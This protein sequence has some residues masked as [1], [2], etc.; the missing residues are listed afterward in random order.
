[1]EGEPLARRSRAPSEGHIP[2]I[3]ASALF[4]YFLGGIPTGLLIGRARGVD[5]TRSGSRNIGA[6]NAF[7]VLGPRWGALVF[8]LDALK[9]LAAS[10]FPRVLAGA[11]F[12][13]LPSTLLAPTLAGGIAAIVG[14]VFT[15]WLKFRGGRGV[16]TSLGVFL[17]VMP[18]PTL[19]ALALWILLV[20]TSRRV[21]VGSIGAAAAYPFL[22]HWFAP[23]ELPRLTLTIVG[24][25]IALLIL[26]RH[27]PNIRRILSGTEPPVVGTPKGERS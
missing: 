18:V 25:A 24:A 14:H 4:G 2:G 22:V 10:L 19:L 13:A 11:G 12:G 26:I 1:M 6:T 9:G 3:I 27:I 23:A 15:P 20:G 21:S 17:G 16:A 5:L 8:V 7:R